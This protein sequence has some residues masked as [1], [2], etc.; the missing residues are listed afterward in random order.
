VL[1]ALIVHT[2][3]KMLVLFTSM[4]LF[5]TKKMFL[6]F[7]NSEMKAYFL[8]NSDMLVLEKHSARPSLSLR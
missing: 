6:T 2:R 8:S 3:H 4:D 5:G 1:I 7:E